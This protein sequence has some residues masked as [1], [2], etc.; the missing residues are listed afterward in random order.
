MKKKSV[1]YRIRRKGQLIAYNLTTP[2]IISKI[3]FRTI[4]KYKLDI[5]HPTTL[6]EKLQWLKLYE[7]PHNEKVII[8]ADKF[9]VR[10]YIRSIGMS[11]ILNEIYCAWDTA[12][13]IDWTQLPNQFV[14]KC[15]HGC[16][17]N[18][19]VSDKSS[20]DVDSIIKKLDM[21]M[22]EDFG[23]FNAE[24][25]YSKIPRKIICERY[26]GGSIINYNIYCFNGKAVF[27]SVAGGLGDGIGEHL[28]YYNV[29][30]SVAPF[31]NRSFPVK[32]DELSTLLPQMVRVAECLAKDFPMVR[33]DL[34]DVDG[35]IILSELTFTPGGALI[36]IEPIEYDKKLGEIL[37]I[38]L[39]MG[40]QMLRKKKVAV[41]CG[42][43]SSERDVSLMS[44]KEVYDS[45]RSAGFKNAY[46]F[47]LQQDN[48]DMLLK[49]K[50]DV[51]FLALH[52]KGGEDG[53]LQGAL[54]V[55]GITYTGPGVTASAICMNKILT[56]RVLTSAGIPTGQYR[57]VKRQEYQKTPNVL[58]EI[59]D[60]LG[61]P[62]II[63][64]PSEGSSIG[65]FLSSTIED[66]NEF[67]KKSFQYDDTVLLEEYLKGIEV[68]IPIIGHPDNPTVLP[69][70]EISA[71]GKFYD[72]DA[73]YSEG[74][75]QH[76][77]PARI[78][79]RM[80]DRIR[81]IAIQAYQTIG[82]IG[83]SRVDMIIDERKGPMVIELNTLPGMTKTSLVP[84]SAKAAG[85]SLPELCEKLIEY[86]LNPNIS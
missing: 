39:E 37:D 67:L 17:Y 77:I 81:Q 2:E 14:L 70:V 33:V 69:I 8:C 25:H 3:Y 55:A 38:S 59:V 45:L 16:G 1:F 52:G 76:I 56:K 23:Q 80:N 68:T 21:W 51:A 24:P 60:E 66:L 11:H 9:R 79:A 84:D 49:K 43:N 30:G 71:K 4:L 13:E 42:G 82:C 5:E 53:T 40:K 15:N 48:I 28:T 58:E 83:I 72:F 73:K 50:P 86:A 54:E 57:V 27:L 29:D 75:A 36:P 19:V 18:I 20:A 34:F 7:W 32:K 12:G 85:C 61:L 63:K 31:K 6:N 65:V 62:I 22:K 78:G 47:D 41:V 74:G 64:A 35:K 10:E 44:G 46:L 26:L